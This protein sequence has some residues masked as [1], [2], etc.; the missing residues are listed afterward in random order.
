MDNI[1]TLDLFL[2]LVGSNGRDHQ[3]HIG[4]L[5]SLYERTHVYYLAVFSAGIV[6]VGSIVGAFIALLAQ[7]EASNA[8]I[9]VTA[10]IA[11]VILLI[12]LVPLAS[13]LNRL[14]R[15]YLDILQV[16]NL[17]AQYF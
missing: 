16:Y 7:R 9:M 4:V 11:L 5:R 12:L 17:L 6:L 14:Q 2:M 8:A 3:T 1:T 13:K 10:I 15:N